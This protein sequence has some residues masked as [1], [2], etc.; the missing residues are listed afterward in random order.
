MSGLIVDASLV[1]AT[2]IPEVDTSAA[3]ETL[4]QH[5]AGLFAPPHLISE[6]TNALTVN[7]RKRVIDKTYRDQAVERFMGLEISLDRDSVDVQNLRRTVALAD[8]HD[9]TIYDAL[10]LELAMRKGHAL[11]TF[12]RD[13]RNAA[14][15]EGVVIS[16]A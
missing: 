7:L 3:H 12:D 14:R 16:P 11:G 9:L 15:R 8:L 5:H 13:L 10:Y 6:V 1:V 2:L 4:E